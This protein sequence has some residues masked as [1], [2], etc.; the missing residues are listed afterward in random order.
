M[1]R[2]K[3]NERIMNELLGEERIIS[4]QY[5]SPSDNKWR[6]KVVS[7][8]IPDVSEEENFGDEE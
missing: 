4:E 6:L 1:R 5:G 2:I 8:T 7:R 3:A